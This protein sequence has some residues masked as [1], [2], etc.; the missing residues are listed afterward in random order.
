MGLGRC[1]LVRRRRTTL[2]G[3]LGNDLQRNWRVGGT[4]AVPIDRKNSIKF[5]VSSG[6]SARTGNDFDLIAIAWQHRW[7]TGF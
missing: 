5:A 2:N 6:V 4:L 3:D 7:G 1:D